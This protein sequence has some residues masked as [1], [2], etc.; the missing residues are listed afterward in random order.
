MPEARG[1]KGGHD[2][3]E[4]ADDEKVDAEEFVARVLVQIPDP[5]RHLLPTSAP[6][7]RSG[8][9]WATSPASTAPT[10]RVS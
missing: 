4:P 2:A 5:R 6:W 10:T 9:S 1:Q 8:T 7:S 3:A